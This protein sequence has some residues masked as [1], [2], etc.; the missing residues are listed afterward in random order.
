MKKSKNVQG[1]TFIEIL[2]VVTIIALLTAAGAVS[3]SQFTKSSRDT[4]RKADMEQIRAAAELYKSNN[5][6]YPLSGSGVGKISLSTCTT[7]SLTDSGGN[8]Y[9]SKLPQDPKCSSNK[10]AYYYVSTDGS[11]YS[12]AARLEGSSVSSCV[13]SP[14]CGVGY[15]CNYCLGP[16]GQTN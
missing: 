8:T 10:P 1:F 7:G 11:T 6:S 3:Y 15:Y 13:A 2:V 5:D 9:L 4:K 16:Y 14:A 12:I